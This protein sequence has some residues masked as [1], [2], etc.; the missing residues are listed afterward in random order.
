MN[1]DDIKELEA[2]VD[3]LATELHGMRQA[4]DV[5]TT[6]ETGHRA[7]Q[8]EKLENLKLS[9]SIASTAAVNELSQ[10][11]DIR[12]NK[13][14]REAGEHIKNCEKENAEQAMGR[15]TR[16]N[17]IYA[18]WVGFGL[19]LFGMIRDFIVKGIAE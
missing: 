18:L 6:A 7:L 19:L 16:L 15:R 3:A 5:H 14:E 1:T 12:L 17:H 8:L 4:F 11:F 2:K 10:R 13:I 9:M